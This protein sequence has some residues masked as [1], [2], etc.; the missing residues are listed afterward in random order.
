VRESE[1]VSGLVCVGR[2]FEA[3]S[4]ILK[5]KPGLLFRNS[6]NGGAPELIRDQVFPVSARAAAL[7][8]RS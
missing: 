3:V 7:P 2:D 4:E 8:G 1:D 6:E 5:R